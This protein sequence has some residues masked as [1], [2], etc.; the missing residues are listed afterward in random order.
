M[1]EISRC[2]GSPFPE[3]RFE[4]CCGATTAEQGG[5][6]TTRLALPGDTLSR[7]L[8]AQLVCYLTPS[9]S[10]AAVMPRALAMSKIRSSSR[11]RRPCSTSIRKFLDTPASRASCSWVRP[12][13]SRARWI[14]RP[15]R[16]RRR[17]HAATLF[18][19]SWLGRVGTHFSN[20]VQCPKVCPTSS[21]LFFCDRPHIPRRGS[22][23]VERCR[24]RRRSIPTQYG[25]HTATSCAARNR[26]EHRVLAGSTGKPQWRD[27][28]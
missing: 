14:R 9:R 28:G 25:A 24:Y 1:A 4:T 3:G 17:S 8:P 13:W 23:R 22:T 16:R 20:S 2:F 10:S 5:L 7:M 12:L 18:G 6:S 15:T 11:L 19:S 26:R 27:L 21:A